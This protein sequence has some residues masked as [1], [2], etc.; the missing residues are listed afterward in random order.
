VASGY[1]HQRRRLWGITEQA[2]DAFDELVDLVIS[3]GAVEEG[4]LRGLF[5]LVLDDLVGPGDAAGHA[6]IQAR[7]MR[8]GF[9]TA[10]AARAWIVDLL[11]AAARQ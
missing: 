6:L 10:A 8:S 7:L 9:P 1:S 5:T 3:P 4:R 11:A 2:V